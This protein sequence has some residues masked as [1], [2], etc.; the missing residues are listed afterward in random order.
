MDNRSEGKLAILLGSGERKTGKF[1]MQ[2][3]W[4]LPQTLRGFDTIHWNQGKH[5]RLPLSCLTQALYPIE[6]MGLIS[7][8]LASSVCQAALYLEETSVPQANGS[9][10]RTGGKTIAGLESSA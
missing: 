4:P 9:S 3:V 2:K 10:F 5:T 6:H 8:L 7:V 1:D